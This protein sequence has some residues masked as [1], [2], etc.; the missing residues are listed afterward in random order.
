MLTDTKLAAIKPPATGQQEHPDHKVKGLRL[1]VGSGG[2]KTWTLRRRV[3]AKVI[4]KKL[5]NYPGMGLAAARDA[6]ERVL[7]ALE[8]D[9][10]TDTLDRTFGVVA[11]RWI[12]DKAKQKNKRWADQERQ[13]E[14]HVLPHWR[15]R[16]MGEIKRRDVRELIDGIEGKVL[17]NRVL[18]LIRPIFRFA[19]AR[20]W[21]DASPAEGIEPPRKEASRDRV[22]DMEE[23]ARVW[24]AAPL[25][26]YPFGQYVRMLMLTA[27]RRTEVAAMRW[28]DV[29]L[30]A[31]TWTIP[32]SETKASRAQLVPLSPT[33]VAILEDAPEIGPFV[34]TT[35]G[36]THIANYAK[37]KSRLDEFLTAKGGTL[38]PWRL[39]DLRR[40]AAT[41]M[42]RLGVS[43]ETTGRVLNHAVAGITA[44]TYGL[45]DYAP[46]K[47]SALDR[48][49]AEIARAVNG[50]KSGNVV[51]I[52]A[53]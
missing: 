43:M 10:T 36:E 13:L 22:L 2:K 1:R 18:A 51:S 24:N 17:P 41:H 26:G 7:V 33:A 23:V 6:A 21:I 45:H 32:A 53:S 37:S 5:G 16:K 47:R 15:D 34:F 49:A 30:K 48:W 50:D 44:T 20:D 11:G 27:Q 4:N 46:E 25:L 42:V 35:D 14:L 8:I 38:A 9:G 40:T 29:D 12:E 28:A 52:N 3:G 19:L 39:H 31:A